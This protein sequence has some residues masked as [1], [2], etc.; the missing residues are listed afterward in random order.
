MRF[1]IPMGILLQSEGDE[2]RTTLNGLKRR[3]KG[4]RVCERQT[5]GEKR[6]MREGESHTGRDQRRAGNVKCVTT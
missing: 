6:E 1:K 5:R 2:E 4:G 3:R